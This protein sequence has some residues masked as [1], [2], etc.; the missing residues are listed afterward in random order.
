MSKKLVVAALLTDL[1]IIMIFH[2]K[3][4]T[5]VLQVLES[6]RT[7]AEVIQTMIEVGMYI[8]LYL[9]VFIVYFLLFDRY[10]C[11]REGEKD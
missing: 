4:A 8:S 5:L 6:T 10:E 7:Y 3:I 2:N 1:I 11:K 9:I